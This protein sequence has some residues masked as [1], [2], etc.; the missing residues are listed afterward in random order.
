[1]PWARMACSEVRS[2]AAVQELNCVNAS[3][4]ID[5]VVK[6]TLAGPVKPRR[7]SSNWILFQAP[8]VTKKSESPMINLPTAL[9]IAFL[10]SVRTNCLCGAKRMP[11]AVP[12]F[13]ISSAAARISDELNK[14]IQSPPYFTDF[15]ITFIQT[16]SDIKTEDL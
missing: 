11:W 10:L 15:S 2:P 5:H 9:R 1:M 16:A 6:N 3:A 14:P 4:E 13:P 12:R 7:Y 8:S